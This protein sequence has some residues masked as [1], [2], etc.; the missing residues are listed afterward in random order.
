MPFTRTT[1]GNETSLVITGTISAAL[2]AGDLP[3]RELKNANKPS[4]IIDAAIT[5]PATAL[6]A[7]RI[8]NRI[9]FGIATIRR[10]DGLALIVAMAADTIVVADGGSIEF[11][12]LPSDP[13]DSVRTMIL[14]TLAARLGESEQT[15]AAYF[16]QKRKL[17]AAEA[18][19][20]FARPHGLNAKSLIGSGGKLDPTKV[21]ARWN[22]PRGKATG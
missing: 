3:V 9:E 13:S 20:L 15:V 10:A 16:A 21:Y 18:S 6:Q 5:D 19:A 8:L 4:L 2:K 12:D 17:N 22:A 1:I 7:Y 14:A 11:G